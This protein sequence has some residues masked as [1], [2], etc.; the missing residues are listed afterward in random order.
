MPLK[1]IKKAIQNLKL[2]P[3]VKK[4]NNITKGLEGT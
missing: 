1:H 2:F 3:K 4:Q